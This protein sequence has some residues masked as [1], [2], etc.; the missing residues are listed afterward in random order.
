MGKSS[1]LLKYW[2]I[3][4]KQIFACVSFFTILSL[5]EQGR[6]SQRRARLL[7]EE[8][9]RGGI[10]C[11]SEANIQSTSFL[12]VKQIVRIYETFRTLTT[13]M[14]VFLSVSSKVNTSSRLLEELNNV[15]TF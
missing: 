6:N 15:G 11:K 3:R 13:I 7:H 8:Q 12:E 1:R 4:W 14:K 9:H 2:K 10:L 5:S